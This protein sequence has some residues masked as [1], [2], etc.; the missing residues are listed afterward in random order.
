MPSATFLMQSDRITLTFPVPELLIN[1]G[2]ILIWYIS[3]FK[4]HQ[5]VKIMS[6]LCTKFPRP[7]AAKRALP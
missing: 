1:S 5:F 4:K 3:A 6:L 7:G 2:G